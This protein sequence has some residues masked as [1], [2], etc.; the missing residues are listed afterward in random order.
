MSGPK[1]ISLRGFHSYFI[2]SA[3]L[4]SELF[5]LT[6][7]DIRVRDGKSTKRT[8]SVKHFLS[9][10]VKDFYALVHLSGPW[11]NTFILQKF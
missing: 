2:F 9:I 7:G 1:E 3:F 8:F 5:F 6:R 4:F 11:D 10:I